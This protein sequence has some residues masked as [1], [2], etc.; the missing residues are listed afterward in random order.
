MAFNIW[1][2]QEICISSIIGGTREE[3]QQRLWGWGQSQDLLSYTW[4]P[5]LKLKGSTKIWIKWRR[6]R[7]VWAHTHTQYKYSL[8]FIIFAFKTLYFSLYSKMMTIIGDWLMRFVIWCKQPLLGV[9]PAPHFLGWP[10]TGIT[11]FTHIHN[12]FNTYSIHVKM[13]TSQSNN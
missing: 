8:S 9:W 1:K 13:V 10:I 12:D 2:T 11:L 7:C 3:L 6:G 5:V 4:K